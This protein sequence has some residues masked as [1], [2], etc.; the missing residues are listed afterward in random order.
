MFIS[1]RYDKRLTVVADT[2]FHTMLDENADV[3]ESL[4][5]LEFIL[6]DGVTI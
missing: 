3:D 5:I 2:M 4:L 1:I 6:R